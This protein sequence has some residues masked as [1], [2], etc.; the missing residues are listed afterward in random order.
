MVDAT[1]RIDGRPRSVRGLLE[2]NKYRLDYYQREYAW[3]RKQI[4]ELIEDLEAKFR[5]S[6]DESHERSEVEDYPQ[7]FL[8][9]V[10][11]SHREKKRYI[12][13]GQQRLTSLTLLL[14]HLY[15]LAKDVDGVTPV[16][17]LIFSERF[18][19]RSFNLEV[20]VVDR[21]QAMEALFKGVAFE[22]H[23]DSPSVRTLLA[24]YEDIKE[25]FPDTLTGH[26]LPYFVDWLLDNVSLIEITA[27]NDDDA[28]TIFETMNDR[29]LSLTPTDMLKGFLLAHIN[30]DDAK[31]KAD[32]TWKKTVERLVQQGGKDTAADFIKAWLRAKYATSIRERKKDAVPRDWDRIGTEFHNWLRNNREAAGLTS[33]APA[34]EF[35][36]PYAEFIHSHF[37]AYSRHY[38]S[39]LD[40][41]LK[42]VPGREAIFYNAHNDF[43]LQFPLI[44][45]PIEIID[46]ATEVDMK[47]RL[48]AD[49]L[50]IYCARRIVNYRQI[51]YS[52][53][54]YTMFNLLR[55][56]RGLSVEQLATVLKRRLQDQPESFAGI[57]DYRLHQMNRP[58]VRYI[59][60]RL[61]AH[62]EAECGVESDFVTYVSSKIKKPFEIE[63]IWADDYQRFK[64][65]FAS[66]QDFSFTR[67]RLGGLILLPRGFNQSLGAND[68]KAKVNHYYGQNLLA[69]T[70]SPQCY[71]NNPS[72]IAYATSSGL[73]F[74]PYENEFT[75]DALDERQDLYRRIAEQVWSP[76]RLDV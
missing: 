43:T 33:S 26:A 2:G 73:P 76:S 60:A 41:T 61:T 36:Q 12:V 9:S 69:K 44:L 16:T 64:D 5:G 24:R 56:I 67:N 59:L 51:G 25:L 52:A 49:F 75:K 21:E 8:G 31:A 48:V 23:S 27:Y 70:L 46:S 6:Y 15:H 55:E 39:I 58:Q 29:G 22:T 7:Y 11:I 19:K 57:S 65:V 50:D 62:I 45:A 74:K 37:A 66:P 40:A 53:M 28:Y 71:Q 18:G 34:A 68:F 10:I 13:D 42:P 4:A 30:G 54:S 14:V 35:T 20:D 17:N 72:F 3:G 38:L 1:N 32:A 63:H 47:M